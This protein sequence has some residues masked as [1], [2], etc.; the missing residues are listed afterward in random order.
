MNRRT[1]ARQ[2]MTLLV[3]ILLAVLGLTAVACGGTANVGNM[4]SG[5]EQVDREDLANPAEEGEE[6]L[7]SLPEVNPPLGAGDPRIVGS[8]D[9]TIEEFVQAIGG[10]LNAKWQALFQ[11]SGYTYANA[12]F[13]LFEEPVPIAG[14]EGVA[15]PK[16]GPFYCSETQGVY[17][18]PNWVDPQGQTPAQIG[19]FAVAM[20]LAHEEGHHVQNLLGILQDPRLYTIQRELQADCLAGIW[21]RSVYEEGSLERGDV[22]EAV[23]SLQNV[24]DLPGTPPTDPGAHGNEQQRVDAFLT[25]FESGDVGQCRF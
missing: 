24:A 20:I 22:E 23:Q 19:D 9:M 18:P 2:P 1:L 16:M 21:G 7:A 3:V 17:Y 14:C 12:D 4:D 15:D 25:G 11:D 10:D 6:V 13:V 8:E 5:E